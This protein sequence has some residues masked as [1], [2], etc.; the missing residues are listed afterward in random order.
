MKSPKKKRF[1]ASIGTIAILIIVTILILPFFKNRETEPVS[2]VRRTSITRI[3]NPV[4]TRLIQDYEKEIRKLMK[5]SNTPGAAIA[6]VRDSTIVY[7]RGLGL[8]ATNAK[9]SVDTNTVF[10]LASVSKC[11]ASF[12]TGMLVEKGVL[13]WTDPVVKYLPEFQLISPEE[14]QLLNIS[15]VLSHT[16]GLPYH[17]YTNLVEEGLDLPSLLAKLKEVKMS[18]GVGKEYSYQN[19]AYSLIGEVIRAA[20]GNT[21][22]AGIRQNLFGPLNMNDASLDYKSFIGNPNIAKPHRLAKRSWVPTRIND[23]YYNVAPAGGINASIQDMGNWMVALLGHRPDVIKKETLQHL[24]AP[25]IDARSRNRNYRKFQ[26]PD[27]SFYGLGWR[28]LHYPND[29]IV[30]HGG[31]VTGYRSEVALDPNNDI[32]ICILSNAPGRLPDNGIPV[33]FNL[34]NKYKEAIVAWERKQ[35]IPEAE[36]PL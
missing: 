24:F 28:I 32:A 23:T 14:T 19:V 18:N 5:A 7:I 36:K 17:T 6:I 16:T 29:T 22:E 30:Y 13:T 35:R 33:F 8:K 12:Y 11:F 21:Y 25:S 1:Y 27:K 4:I 26:R 34:F 15:H 9:D 3:P 31:Y 2:P 20:T 10:R